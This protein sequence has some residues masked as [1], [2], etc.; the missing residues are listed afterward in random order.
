VALGSQPAARDSGYL[1]A[2]YYLR[3]P[4]TSSTS[5]PSPT[6]M[7]TAPQQSSF[8]YS[9]P[10]V[11]PVPRLSRLPPANTASGNA[12]PSTGGASPP[13]GGGY[14]YGGQGYDARRRSS[15]G[16]DLAGGD[17]RTKPSQVLDDLLG[18]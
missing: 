8:L 12:R 7:H 4:A 1:P 17:R 11:P 2:G 15:Q 10:S 18:G 16:A 9:D 6:K 5:G 3:E 14:G 13:V